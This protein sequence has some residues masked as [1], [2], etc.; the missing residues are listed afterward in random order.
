MAPNAS[1]ALRLSALAPPLHRDWADR[2]RMPCQQLPQ[3]NE[4]AQRQDW[5][6]P[7]KL[8]NSV[9]KPTGATPLSVVRAGGGVNS[10]RKV[11]AFPFLALFDFHLFYSPCS[12]A[13]FYGRYCH[14][15]HWSTEQNEDDSGS[16]KLPQTWR[17][18]DLRDNWNEKTRSPRAL[19]AYWLTKLH[20]SIV[21]QVIFCVLPF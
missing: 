18:K 21:W 19:A 8:Y 9:N 4:R 13:G 11:F 7:F 17:R 12:F 3:W 2:K 14:W 1:T 15:S 5:I 20:N 6:P 16:E 10:V